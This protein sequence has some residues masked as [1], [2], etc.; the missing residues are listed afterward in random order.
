[1]DW[2]LSST[3]TSATEERGTVPPVGAEMGM[4]RSAS[5]LSILAPLP[6]T[7]T[8]KSLPSI[9]TVVAVVPV[10]SLRTAEPMVAE[11]SP[12]CAAAA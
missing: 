11:V 2:G 7:T 6:R 4:E 9:V 5:R 3:E 10:N 8:S 12:Y 1:M